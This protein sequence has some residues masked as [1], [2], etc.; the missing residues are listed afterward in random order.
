MYMT[1]MISVGSQDRLFS[2]K[3]LPCHFSIASPT[4]K[5]QLQHEVV[6]SLVDDCVYS[7]FLLEIATSDVNLLVKPVISG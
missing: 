5:Y 1:C 4:A 7:G 6:L 3:G 2:A